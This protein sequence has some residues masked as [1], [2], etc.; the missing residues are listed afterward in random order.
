MFLKGGFHCFPVLSLLENQH[1]LSRNH[2]SVL[3]WRKIKHKIRTGVTTF[4]LMQMSVI[5]K[6]IDGRG[7]YFYGL[8]K[9]KS[10]L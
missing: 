5:L 10:Q 6:L 8:N 4:K 7:I 3:L 1:N 2:A 9:F